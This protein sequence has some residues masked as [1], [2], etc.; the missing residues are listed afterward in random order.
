MSDLD[1]CTVC[2]SS[3]PRHEPKSIYDMMLNKDQCDRC[4]YEGLVRSR[5][6]LPKPFKDP[7]PL[8]TKDGVLPEWARDRD[9]YF[10]VQL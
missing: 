1:I 3:I 6:L 4:V 7:L 10:R 8:M 2:G 5:R 9:K